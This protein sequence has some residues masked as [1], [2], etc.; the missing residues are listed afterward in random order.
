MPTPGARDS[1]TLWFRCW[2]H[3]SREKVARFDDHS[4]HVAAVQLVL[5]DG[6]TPVA[7]PRRAGLG[8]TLKGNDN[9]A[10]GLT[11]FN[12]SK[13]SASQCVCFVQHSFCICIWLSTSF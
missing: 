5:F 11:A 6:G 13:A 7:D 1:G 8:F 3:H 4:N 2:V 12:N 9:V 10:V